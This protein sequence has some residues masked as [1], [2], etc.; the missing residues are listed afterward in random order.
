MYNI[1]RHLDVTMLDSKRVFRQAA[2]DWVESWLEELEWEDSP[3]AVEEYCGQKWDDVHGGELP[4][5][6]VLEARNE[7]V[8]Y[9]EKRGE[10]YGLCVRFRNAGR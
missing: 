7:E 2:V 6:K 4:K 3:E 8:E 10:A 9:M 1:E 5:E